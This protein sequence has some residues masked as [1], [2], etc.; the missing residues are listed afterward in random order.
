MWPVDDIHKN[1]WYK[2]II[3]F[4]AESRWYFFDGNPKKDIHVLILFKKQ[5]SN[6]YPV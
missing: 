6:A 2:I 5:V 1:D 4:G 3:Y